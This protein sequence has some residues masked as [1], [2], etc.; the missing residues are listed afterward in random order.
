MANAWTFHSHRHSDNIALRGDK[1][2]EKPE[3]DTAKMKFTRNEE[4]NRDL[5]KTDHK[6][7]ESL[8]LT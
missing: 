3:Y 7:C 8:K 5:N 4:V 2:G 1:F 6:G